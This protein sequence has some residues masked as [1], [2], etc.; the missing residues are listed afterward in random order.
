VAKNK[1]SISNIVIVALSLC[2]VAAIIVSSVAVSLKPTRQANK[3]LDRAKN[4]LIAA[5]LFEKGTTNV[6]Q[7]DELFKQFEIRVV[8]LKEGKLLTASEAQ[9]LGIDPVTFEQRKA[10]KDPKV[11]RELGTSE[12]I[13]SIS[14]QAN[15]S[16]AYLLKSGDKI[17]RIVLPIH[18][19]G[20][21]STLY[22]F[23]ALDGDMNTVAGITFYEHQ[24]TAGLGGEVDNPKWKASWEGK[25][26]Y[27]SNG[28]VALTVIKGSVD[29][30]N[31]AAVHQIDGLSG[32]SLTSRGVQNLIQFWMGEQGFGP[33][34]EK[35]KG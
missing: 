1:D 7:I 25:E 13:A 31:A 35:L 20:L 9:A 11:S 2:L 26:I 30:A 3:E 5:G 17:D 4:I 22:G 6:S 29:P 32:A 34:L 21:W 15:Y 8:D 16:V 19:Y 33:I 12:D 18:G 14:R 10:A 23:L 24:E 27:G 28:S